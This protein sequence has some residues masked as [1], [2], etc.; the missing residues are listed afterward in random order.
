M[1]LFHAFLKDRGVGMIGVEAGGL[2]VRTGQHAARFAGGRLG[3][4]QGARTYVLQD[5][6]GQIQLTHSVSAGLDYAAVGPE[7]AWLRDRGRAEY[8]HV[9]DTEAVNA[10]NTLG[11]W[12]GILPALESAHAVA[13]VIRH[14]RRWKKKDLVIIN[15]SGRGDKDVQQV[16]DW[17][18]RHGT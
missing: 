17:Q 13:Y 2:G 15:L 16:A 3:V 10:F 7:H 5:R 12:E 6:F 8:S 4:L 1:G 14:A 11:R 9:T 18:K